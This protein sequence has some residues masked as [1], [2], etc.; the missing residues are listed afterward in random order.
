MPLPLAR[1]ITLALSA[2]LPLAA[3]QAQDA[4]DP[5][6]GPAAVVSAQLE[7]FARGDDAGIAKAFAFASPRNRDNTGPLSRFTMMIREGYPELIGHREAELSA[8]REDEQHAYQGVE[9]IGADG[10]EH[11]YIFILS[12]YKLSDCDGCW[13]TDGVSKRPANPDADAL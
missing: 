12:R 1:R 2:L 6:L 8:L 4:P 13:M 9:V 5:E 3:A 10:R 7:G 11:L